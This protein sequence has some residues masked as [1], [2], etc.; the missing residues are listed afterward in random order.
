MSHSLAHLRMRP[1]EAAQ[2]LPVAH[3]H[4]HAHARTRTRSSLTHAL[5]T[6]HGAA[7]A[8]WRVGAHTPAR[9]CRQSGA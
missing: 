9:T 8:G 3:L 1:V 4:T 6:R 7:R 2:A 5:R